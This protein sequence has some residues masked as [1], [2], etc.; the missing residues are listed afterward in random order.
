MLSF[1]PKYSTITVQSAVCQ[2]V[3]I[4]CSP[5]I[6]EVYLYLVSINSVQPFSFKVSRRK[7]IVLRDIY[8]YGERRAAH[9]W[10]SYIIIIKSRHT[11]SRIDKNAL[12]RITGQGLILKRFYSINFML[13]YFFKHFDWLLTFINQSEC[14]KNSLA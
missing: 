8:W 2:V 10:W 9:N 3:P 12:Y 14:L 7:M 11:L 5:S 13:C 4:L 1:D 6:T